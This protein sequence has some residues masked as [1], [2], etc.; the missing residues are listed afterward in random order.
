MPQCK[1]TKRGMFT[2]KTGY[3]AKPHHPGMDMKM[4]KVNVAY[5]IIISCEILVHGIQELHYF[6]SNLIGFLESP[7]ILE[8]ISFQVAFA[9][10]PSQVREFVCI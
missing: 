4:E 5:A 2:I 6:V 7:G 1:N 10:C 8:D 9:S 3:P